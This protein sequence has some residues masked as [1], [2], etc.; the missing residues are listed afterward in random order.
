MDTLG[1]I[2]LVVGLLL[3]IGLSLAVRYLLHGR[4]LKLHES[5][6]RYVLKRNLGEDGELDQV[7]SFTSEQIEEI[8]KSKLAQYPDLL[9]MHFDFRTTA[10][11]M[12]EII[13][14]E[15]TYQDVDQIPDE[16]VR[17]AIAEAVAEFNRE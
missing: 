16:R 3:A 2:V 13:F 1:I 4:R 7:S 17:Q 12:L 14:G 6:T 10:G 8:V 5:G 15:R 11:G 9:E